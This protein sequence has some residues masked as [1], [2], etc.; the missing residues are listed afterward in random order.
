MAFID[1][2]RRGSAFCDF[3]QP[4][5]HTVK[6]GICEKL[7]S[8]LSQGFPG[9]MKSNIIVLFLLLIFKKQ[10]AMMGLSGE[11]RRWA[12]R[13]AFKEN[14]FKDILGASREPIQT[15]ILLVDGN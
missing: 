8:A 1:R 13:R 7:N 5:A 9:K 11:C 3:S 4:L 14:P 6:E 2:L 15:H 12:W 10:V